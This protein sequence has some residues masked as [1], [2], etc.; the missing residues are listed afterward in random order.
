MVFTLYRPCSRF[1]SKIC[2]TKKMIT[3]C[4]RNWKWQL[5]SGS[6]IRIEVSSA[7]VIFCCF[8]LI[9]DKTANRCSTSACVENRDG[10]PLRPQQQWRSAHPGAWHAPPL[11]S[12]QGSPRPSGQR[13]HVR[14][15]SATFLAA[16]L[17]ELGVSAVV[18]LGRTSG[19]ATA[20]FRAGFGPGSGSRR[21]GWPPRG[22]GWYTRPPGRPDCPSES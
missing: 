17:L 9:D 16:L 19:T 18:C 10:K 14:R 20:A 21:R 5:A 8:T 2:T 4:K 1:Y 12:T 3:W 6:F 22:C 7:V 13:E 11:P 15:F